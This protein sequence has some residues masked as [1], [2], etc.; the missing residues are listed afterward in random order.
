MTTHDMD[1]IETIINV[2]I[3]ILITWLIIVI[4]I[5]G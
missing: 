4:R 5:N 1:I 2:A 3:V